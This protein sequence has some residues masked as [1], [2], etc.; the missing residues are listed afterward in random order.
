MVVDNDGGHGAIERSGTVML[1]KGKAYLEV[2]YF[3]EAGGWWLD[4]YYTGP[5]IPKQIIPADKLF[6]KPN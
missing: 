5:D 2:D 3:N 6:L 1:E 4:T